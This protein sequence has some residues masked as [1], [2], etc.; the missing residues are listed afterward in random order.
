MCGGE[1]VCGG[2]ISVWGRDE[3]VEVCVGE[4]MS[5]H[6]EVCVAWER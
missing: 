3:C 6:G 5:L 2:G 1:R 4:E